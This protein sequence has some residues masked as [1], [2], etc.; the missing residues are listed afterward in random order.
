MRSVDKAKLSMQILE[1]EADFYSRNRRPVTRFSH[2]RELEEYAGSVYTE[3]AF[4]RFK[5]EVEREKGLSSRLVQSLNRVRTYFVMRYRRPERVLRVEVHDDEST[6][7][8]SCRKFEKEGIPCRH[9]INIMKVEDMEIIPDAMVLRR[10][11]I[12]CGKNNATVKPF[13]IDVEDTKIFWQASLRVL[14]NKICEDANESDLAFEEAKESLEKL[15]ESL[16]MMKMASNGDSRNRDGAQVSV[17]RPVN[18]GVHGVTGQDLRKGLPQRVD[19]VE[20]LAT[21]VGHVKNLRCH[22]P[23]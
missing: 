19:I 8:C 12:D 7:K 15:H 9:T 5:K 22:H 17:P 13:T 20:E 21:Q 11:R 1:L 16:L 4:A 10:W 23:M 18:C 6:I 3:R 2:L 14:C